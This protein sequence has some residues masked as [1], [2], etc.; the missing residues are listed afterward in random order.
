MDIPGARPSAN[1]SLDADSTVEYSGREVCPPVLLLQQLLRAHQIFLL[2]HSPTL[3]ELYARLARPRFCYILK[4]YWDNYILDWDLLLNG[5]PAVDVFNGLKLAAGGELGIGVG[6]EEWGSGEREV[7]EDFVRRTDGLVDLIV[8]RFG[9]SKEVER[10][11]DSESLLHGSPT[12]KAKTV[13]ECQGVRQHPKPSDGVIFS[14]IGAITRSSVKD[15]S[16]WVELLYKYGQRAYGVQDNPAAVRRKRR[17]KQPLD[18]S[19]GGLHNKTSPSPQRR[20]LPIR[21]SFNKVTTSTSETR[22][23]SPPTIPPPIVRPPYLSAEVTNTSPPVRSSSKKVHQSDV[24]ME[25]DSASGTDM[26]MKYLTLGVY[27]STWGI[28]SRKVS[29]HERPPNMRKGSGPSASSRKAESNTQQLQKHSSS[30][31]HFLIGLQGE[32]EQDVDVADDVGRKKTRAEPGGFED[33]GR[34]GQGSNERTI[35]RTLQVHRQKQKSTGSG[36]SLEN[37]GI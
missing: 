28:P 33:Q 20:K 18:F 7:L 27:G 14:G 1:G 3:A 11:L 15:V 25:D 24:Q 26:L 30:C 35:L 21:E 5:N 2:H 17:E 29:A 36:T 37:A 9:D 34:N 8:S 10:T 12:I 22:S 32:L 4:R 13:D 31:G 19:K 23:I 6:E 16:S